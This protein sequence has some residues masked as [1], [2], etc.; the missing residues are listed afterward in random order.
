MSL[1]ASA[2]FALLLTTAACAGRTGVETRPI[3]PDNGPPATIHASMSGPVTYRQVESSFRLSEDGYALVGHLGGDGMI[4]VIYPKSPDDRRTKIPAR[5]WMR[6]D[7]FD[8]IYDFAPHRYSFATEPMRGAGASMDSYDGR[9]HGFIFLITSREPLDFQPL[10]DGFEFGEMDVA[11]YGSMLDPR[12]A[13]RRVADAIAGREGYTLKFANALSTQNYAARFNH[14]G[15]ASGFASIFSRRYYTPMYDGYYGE[16]DIF[17][18]YFGSWG[19]PMWYSAPWGRL[20]SRCGGYAMNYAYWMFAPRWSTRDR[21]PWVEYGSPATPGG[22]TP[23]ITRL[24]PGDEGRQATR[25]GRSAMDRHTIVTRAR[26]TETSERSV[27]RDR[28]AIDNF[29]TSREPAPRT[30]ARSFDRPGSTRVLE[31]PRYSRP[32]SYGSTSHGSWGTRDSYSDW[33]RGARSGSSSSSS[34]SARPAESS[35][36]S[37]TASRPSGG[38]SSGSSSTSGSTAGRTP[39]KQ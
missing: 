38:G 30:H 34:E 13:V 17:P 29:L 11:D 3:K 28:R 18:A 35:S 26:D 31:A 16:F 32:G 15:C 9:G 36:G 21:Y 24:R 20:A 19:M 14:F 5:T 8:A 23:I 22:V 12:L 7:K 39:V 1:R 25:K 27:L 4:R 33:A 6:T 37:S 2:G 10:M